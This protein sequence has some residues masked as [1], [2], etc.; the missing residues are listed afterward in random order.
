MITNG[1]ISDII[2]NNRNIVKHL[3]VTSETSVQALKTR[4][5]TLTDDEVKQILSAFGKLDRAV[6]QVRDTEIELSVA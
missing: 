5:S 4:L 1:T 3:R 6:R 2:E